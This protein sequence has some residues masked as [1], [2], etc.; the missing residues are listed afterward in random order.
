ME[1]EVMYVELKTILTTRVHFKADGSLGDTEVHVSVEPDE[2]MSEL[3]TDLI[4]RF[5]YTSVAKAAEG[6]KPGGEYDII[7]KS[8]GEDSEEEEWGDE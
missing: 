6:M 8:E 7:E 2:T 3:P 1:R 4:M 5:A